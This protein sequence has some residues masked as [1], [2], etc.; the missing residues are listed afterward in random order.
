MAVTMNML[1]VIH[2]PKPPGPVPAGMKSTALVGPDSL[3]SAPTSPALAVGGF[4]YWPMSYIDNRVSFGIVSYDPKGNLTNQLE[5]KGARYVYKITLEEN[6]GTVTFW[7]QSN[8]KVT[9]TL[10]QVYNLLM[11]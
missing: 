6:S 2:L 11:K 4:T 8:Q 7:G 3:Q 1:S 5:V 9:L 10:D